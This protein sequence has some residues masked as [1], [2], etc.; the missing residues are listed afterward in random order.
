M[1]FTRIAC[2][3]DSLTYGMAWTSAGGGTYV[4]VATPYPAKMATDLAQTVD[5]YGEGG[6]Y[7]S[8]ILNQWRTMVQPTDAGV[9]CVWGGIN[10]SNHDL[11][12]STTIANLSAIISEAVAEGRGVVILT[13]SPYK[14]W[15]EH[16]EPTGW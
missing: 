10:D 11:S 16:G 3:G 12:A 6:D 14:A 15:G 5:N 2:I 13:V 1:D 8:Q 4:R 7:T 9:V